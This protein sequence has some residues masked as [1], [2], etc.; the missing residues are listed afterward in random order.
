MKRVFI[1]DCEGPISKNDNAF[2]LTANFVPN[3]DRLFSLISKYD[4][5]LA[6]V[7]KRP[8]YN[9]GDTLKLILPFLKAFDLTDKLMRDFSARNLVLMAGSKESLKYISGKTDAFIISTSYEHYIQALCD[10]MEFPFENTFAT[11]LVLDKYDLSEKEKLKLREMAKEIAQRPMITIPDSAISIESFTMRDQET[12]SLLD[13]IFWKDITPMRIGNVFSEVQPVGGLQKAEAVK[14]VVKSV[15]VEMSDVVYVGDSITDVEAFKLVRSNG[16]LTLS[17][18]GNRY[19]VQSSE[20]VIMSE[21]TIATAL[22]ADLFSRFSKREVLEIV[23]NWNCEA[24]EASGASEYIIEK[25]FAIHQT[26]L[27]K[28]KIVTVEN[29]KMLVQESSEFRTRVRG[30]AIGRLG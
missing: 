2:E 26:T 27:P 3:G 6:E 5:V 1:S 13:E 9:A 21:N 29:E 20:V 11:R 17:F 10:E 22:I 16:G 19:A 28:V 8:D 7:F 14:T 12:I 24:L 15:G 30:Q 4:D 18:N 23:R 25:L